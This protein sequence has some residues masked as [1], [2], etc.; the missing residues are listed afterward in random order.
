MALSILGRFNQ[1]CDQWQKLFF[2]TNYIIELIKLAVQLWVIDFVPFI[3]F[4][5]EQQQGAVA[6]NIR[7]QQG[8]KVQALRGRE[9][10]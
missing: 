5:T 3:R 2:A 6:D 8:R 9:L 1:L 7:N 10:L 4:V